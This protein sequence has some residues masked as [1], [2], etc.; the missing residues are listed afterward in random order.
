M[1]KALRLLLFAVSG[2]CSMRWS[3]V[4]LSRGSCYRCN[5]FQMRRERL[6]AFTALGFRERMVNPDAPQPRVGDL[7]RAGAVGSGG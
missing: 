5:L 6:P 1:G 2:A 7:A 3:F 4:L